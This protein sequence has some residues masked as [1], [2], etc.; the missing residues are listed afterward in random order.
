[1]AL[2]AALTGLAGSYELRARLAAAALRTTG[3]RTDRECA[4]AHGE[5]FRAVSRRSAVPG[6][7][8]AA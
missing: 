5:F 4:V 7:W 2:G 6:G 8:A 3:I 1:V